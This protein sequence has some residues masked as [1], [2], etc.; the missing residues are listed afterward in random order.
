[1][2]SDI[3][4]MDRAYNDVSDASSSDE[5]AEDDLMGVNDQQQHQHSKTANQQQQQS[6]QPPRPPPISTEWEEQSVDDNGYDTDEGQEAILGN[7]RVSFNLP[8]SQQHAPN[9]NSNATTESVDVGAPIPSSSMVHFRH[10]N[11]RHAADFSSPYPTQNARSAA[12]TVLDEVVVTRQSTIKPIPGG[13]DDVFSPSLAEV[14][15]AFLR[16]AAQD[17]GIDT[18]I[19]NTA[20]ATTT[21][22][23]DHRGRLVSNNSRDSMIPPNSLVN[24]RTKTAFPH[25]ISGTNTTNQRS[26]PDS[27]FYGADASALNGTFVSIRDL[28]DDDDV[29]SVDNVVVPS[30]YSTAGKDVDFPTE[31]TSLLG[32]KKSM[33]WQGGFF[34]SQMEKED[35]KERRKMM[36]AR[37]RGLIADGIRTLRSLWGDKQ[38]VDRYH[39]STGRGT[40]WEATHPIGENFMYHSDTYTSI[41]RLSRRFIFS[42]FVIGVLCLHLS[43]C[44]LHDLFLRY[45]AYRNSNGEGEAEVSWN[46]EG[47]YIPPYWVSFEGRVLN[48][49]V[50]PG[51]RTL[52]GFGAMVPGLVLSRG[53][54]WR[55]ATSLFQTSSL[56]QLLLHIWALRT[57]V[58]GSMSSLE[59]R[60]GTMV[61]CI[62][63]VISALVGVAWSIA[64]EPGRL[65]TA[66]GMGIA[67]LLGTVTVDHMCFPDVSKEE[68]DDAG[69][70]SRR[71][72]GGDGLNGISSTSNE[73]FAYLPPTS[74]KKK[75][76][77]LL[78]S[79]SPSLLLVLELLASWW[80]AYTSLPGTALSVVA[81]VTCALLLFVGNPP[82]GS[83]DKAFHHDLLFSETLPPPPPPPPLHWRDDDDS[84]DTSVDTGRQAFNTPL[85]RRSILVDEEDDEEPFGS[86]S[87]LRKRHGNGTS[88][89]TPRRK[90]SYTSNT[91]QSSAS[92][93]IARVVGMLLGLL[94]VVI[95]ASLIATGDGPSNEV[96][97]ASVLGCRPM[98]ILYKEDDT[99][100]NNLECAGGCIPLS[101]EQFARRAEGM[102]PGRCDAIGYSCWHQSGTMTMRNYKV[103][104][105]V[106]EV[107]SADGCANPA[108]D[109]G[110]GY[111]N[112]DDANA[113]SAEFANNGEVEGG[114]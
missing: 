104:I 51:A 38:P 21:T 63:F 32:E 67:G 81:G 64:L 24:R 33:P 99:S 20:A 41:G 77:N 18:S 100:D 45:I 95:P 91:K 59:W 14:T 35:R 107:P 10:L 65:I 40:P 48:P 70:N 23:A 76:R 17:L 55:I 68:G 26:A 101:R 112:N 96:T 86:S 37:N 75:R 82:P 7:A 61:A 102:R 15:P 44:G 110:Q 85:M 30:K 4:R 90:E 103:N 94:L 56:V 9:D 97:R 83:F 58:G 50:G 74:Q 108:N 57:T 46:G 1:M 109:D 88:A 11:N 29:P 89:T 105:G 53:Q 92:R 12:D 13:N 19:S 3:Y 87:L 98:R 36:H 5:F 27:S 31:K 47:R 28:S 34:G 106:Y 8:Y 16:R 22:A 71:T 80:A 72:D 52:T 43:L 66:S 25:N 114:K 62:V 60:R 79:G 93:L 78:N 111:K 69:M 6:P 84:A 49:C 113:E 42:R 73:Q 2:N 39:A 54:G